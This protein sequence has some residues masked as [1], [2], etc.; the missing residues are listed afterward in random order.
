MVDSGESN[1]HNSTSVA[2]SENSAK[3]TPAPSQFAPSGEGL[4][5]QMVWLLIMEMPAEEMAQHGGDGNGEF[6]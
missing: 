6:N 3:F 4:P 5:G 1:R 2:L